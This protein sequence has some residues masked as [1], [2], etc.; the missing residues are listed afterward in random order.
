M[1]ISRRLLGQSWALLR[2]TLSAAAK[3]NVPSLGAALAYYTL[4]SMA[5]LLLIV[6]ALAGAVFGQQAA[7]GEMAAQLSQL[8]GPQAALTVQSLLSHAGPESS[9]WLASVIGLVALL[10]GA[11]TVFAELRQAMDRMW[12][13]P[14]WPRA[15]G[16]WAWVHTRLLSLG[17][18]LGIGFLLL[19]SLVFSA[20]IA[21]L[22]RWW[23]PLLAEPAWLAAAVDV[24]FSLCLVGASFAMLFKWMPPVTLAWRDVALAS[25][26]TALLFT[27]GKSVIGAWLLASGISSSFGAAGSLVAML[28]W[29]YYSAQIFLL[30]AE[31]TK[32]Y[33]TRHGSLQQGSPQP[34]AQQHAL[35]P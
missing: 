35:P 17:M 1:S 22:S 21:V 26:G 4:F 13:Q 16:V 6:V 27:L 9:G 2:D 14:S 25:A 8:L 20:A 30:G 34:S 15:S 3:D 11:T 31:F 10:I 29:I 18:I 5:P 28:V 24:L 32:V 33:A 12:A 19:V 23:E 7:R